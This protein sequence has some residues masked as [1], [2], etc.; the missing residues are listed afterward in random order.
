MADDAK[1]KALLAKY[2]AIIADG[3]KAGKR[4]AADNLQHWL[5]GSGKDRKLSSKWLRGFASV[6][7]AEKRNQRRFEKETLVPLALKLGRSYSTVKQDYWDAKLTASVFGELYYASG[8]S[9]L[10]SRG[11]FALARHGDWVQIVGIVEHH[12]WDP[13]DWHANL[14]AF[15]PGHGSVS[16]ADALALEKAGY[17]KPFGMYSFWHQAFQ[18]KYGID[19]GPLWFDEEDFSW[20]EVHDGRVRDSKMKVGHHHMHVTTAGTWSNKHKAM[21]DRYGNLLPGLAATT[22]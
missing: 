3:R 4:V 13:Y 17:G 12:W 2:R 16:D 14:A 22:P 7:G 11:K 15:V 5:D 18:G 6:T 8:T 19:T 10:T 20:G 1:T 21:T 9:T